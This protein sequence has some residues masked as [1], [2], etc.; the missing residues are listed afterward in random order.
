MG[1]QRGQRRR[2]HARQIAGTRART[3][4]FGVRRRR[5]RRWIEST[6]PPPLCPGAGEPPGVGSLTLALQAPFRVRI[7]SV[8]C[9]RTAVLPGRLHLRLPGSVCGKSGIVRMTIVS[10]FLWSILRGKALTPGAQ[11]LLSAGLGNGLVG[12]AGGLPVYGHKA[13]LLGR[14]RC[15]CQNLIINPPYCEKWVGPQLQFLRQRSLVWSGAPSS[16][17]W[18]PCDGGFGSGHSNLHFSWTSLP[19]HHVPESSVEAEAPSQPV[20]CHLQIFLR[21]SGLHSGPFLP[22]VVLGGQN[23]PYFLLPPNSPQQDLSFLF[24]FPTSGESGWA[25]C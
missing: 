24:S 14:K 21:V 18:G 12:G 13:K 6:V 2:G 22:R 17:L 23:Y 7:L 16:S 8:P 20:S 3:R 1:S 19:F 11:A 10:G 5:R 4:G 15:L 25:Q 9:A